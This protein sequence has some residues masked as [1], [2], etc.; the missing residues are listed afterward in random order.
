MSASPGEHWLDRIA[1]PHT[2]R[3]GLRAMLAGAALTLPLAA[4]EP[5]AGSNSCRR[6]CNYTSHREYAARFEGCASN[7]TGLA[8]GGLAVGTLL[9][10]LYGLGMEGLALVNL[11]RC[12]DRAL[13][14]HKARQWDCLQPGCAGFNPESEY[15][16]C[17]NCAS[18]NGC[19]CCP[20]STA[21][22]GYTYCSSLSGKCCS[23]SGGCQNCNPR[24]AGRRGS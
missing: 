22:T 11:E 20:D 8:V 4:A 23:A 17:V 18:I 14:E 21:P 7:Q 24:V 6:G 19:Q 15:G 16:P 10:P 12:R 3:Q 9:N 13:L 2:R 5:A 1:A